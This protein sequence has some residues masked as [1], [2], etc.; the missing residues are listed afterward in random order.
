MPFAGAAVTNAQFVPLTVLQKVSKCFSTYVPP[1]VVKQII[2]A[3]SNDG[4]VKVFYQ[5]IELKD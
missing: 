3:C 5:F 2:V 4:Q 1:A